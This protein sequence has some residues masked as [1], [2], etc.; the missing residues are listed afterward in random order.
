M[1]SL[2]DFKF[3]KEL[4]YYAGGWGAAAYQDYLFVTPFEQEQDKDAF[5]LVDIEKEKIIRKY[6]FPEP[7]KDDCLLSAISCNNK[8][9]VGFFE[10]SNFDV[11]YSYWDIKTGNYIN[12]I[13]AENIDYT[14]P[15]IIKDHLLLASQIY[16]LNSSKLILS[17]ELP[18]EEYICSMIENYIFTIDIG[19]ELNKINIYLKIDIELI[20][21]FEFKAENIHEISNSANFFLIEFQNNPHY[22]LVSLEDLYKYLLNQGKLKDFL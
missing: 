10:D 5:L 3:V 14:S 11:F 1:F 6:Q 9:V 22:Y 17:F 15:K 2:P 7:P 19:S 16:D 13:E 20:Y 12:Q 18:E 4:N 21:S 8:F